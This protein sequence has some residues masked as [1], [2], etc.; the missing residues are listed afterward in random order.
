M[1]NKFMGILCIFALCVVGSILIGG[2]SEK[3]ETPQ[4]KRKH[5]SVKLFHKFDTKEQKDD[6]V[7]QFQDVFEE[8][9]GVLLAS[10]GVRYTWQL[11]TKTVILVDD[12]GRTSIPS[13]RLQI[14]N[15][16]K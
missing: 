11:E 10:V 8:Q 9:K 16:Q 15:K 2:E 6:F 3:K 14:Y 7:Q 1:R 4:A 12:T 5:T 13:V